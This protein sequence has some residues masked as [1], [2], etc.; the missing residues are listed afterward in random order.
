MYSCF[1]GSTFWLF[2]C[3]PTLTLY[4]AV[5]FYNPSWLQGWNEYLA[6]IGEFMVWNG[7]WHILHFFVRFESFYFR[8]G[9]FKQYD[10][11][12]SI[13][14]ISFNRLQYFTSCCFVEINFWNCIVPNVIWNCLL[15]LSRKRHKWIVQSG[16]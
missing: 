10:S 11:Q 16:L 13:S 3:D 12:R 14:K 15:T 8:N 6:V 4:Y 1:F 2:C 9:Y 5:Y 7:L